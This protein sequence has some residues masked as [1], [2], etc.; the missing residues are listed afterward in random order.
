MNGIQVGDVYKECANNKLYK[1]Q[2]ID[3]NGYYIILCSID[4][5][6]THVTSTTTFEAQYIESKGLLLKRKIAN[7]L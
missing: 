4:N 7:I 3:P 1:V 2:K 6:L 5:N